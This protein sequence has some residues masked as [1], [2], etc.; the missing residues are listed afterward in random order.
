MFKNLTAG[1]T[2]SELTFPYAVRDSIVI[3]GGDTTNPS[4]T[5]QLYF[6]CHDVVRVT[7]SAT[8]IGQRFWLK[9]E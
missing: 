7:H 4:R 6:E 8:M 1:A 3:I 9:R 2:L 5:W